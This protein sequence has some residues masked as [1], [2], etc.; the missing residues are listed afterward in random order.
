[1]RGLTK[2]AALDLGADNIRVVSVHPGSIRAAMPAGLEG[3][4]MYATKPIPR[5]GEPEEVAKL[6]LYLVADATYS[7]GIDFIADGGGTVG[8]GP[9]RVGV[10]RC[11]DSASLTSL[12]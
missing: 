1:M 5:I 11:S 10:F 6:I 12:G 9:E 8:P 3:S 4:E 7:T 2:A